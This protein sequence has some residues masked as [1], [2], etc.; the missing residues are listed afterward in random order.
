[1]SKSTWRILEI[2]KIKSLLN[3]WPNIKFTHLFIDQINY[4]CKRLV[5]P[6]LLCNISN[7]DFLNFKTFSLIFQFNVWET[8]NKQFILTKI[9]SPTILVTPVTVEKEFW[10]NWSGISSC[11]LSRLNS[12]VSS[13]ISPSKLTDDSIDFWL[14]FPDNADGRAEAFAL[15][16]K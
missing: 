7:G 1:M 10:N 15:P 4:W 14:F 11:T 16:C 9:K 13:G 8:Q 5:L 3:I 12:G 6:K 2:N